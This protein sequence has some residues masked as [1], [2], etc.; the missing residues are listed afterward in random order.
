MIAS[1]I[2][3]QKR[4]TASLQSSLI[5]S[6]VNSSSTCL[7]IKILPLLTKFRT[8]SLRIMSSRSHKHNIIGSRR[9]SWSPRR[10][11][12]SD[13]IGCEILCSYRLTWLWFILISLAITVCVWPASQILIMCQQSLFCRVWCTMMSSYKLEIF[14]HEGT[15]RK[16]WAMR[17]KFRFSK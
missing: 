5:K 2:N 1:M 10:W 17:S 11:S 16:A 7:N 14:V 9:D 15:P 8:R 6:P 4:P 13:I 12:V 3:H